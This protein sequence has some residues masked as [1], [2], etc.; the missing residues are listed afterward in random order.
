MLLIAAVTLAVYSQTRD[1]GFISYDDPIYTTGNQM[2]Q[3]G[4]TLDGIVWA[5]TEATAH[6]NYWAPLTWIS[7]LID[8]ELYGMDPGGFHLTNMLLHIVNAVLLFTTFRYLTGRLWES[9][10]LA[11]FFAVHPLHVE[12]VAWISERKDMV[13]TLFWILTIRAYAHYVRQPNFWR[14]G[15]MFFLFLCCLMGKPMG[16]TLPFVLLLMDYWPLDRYARY[17][18]G[19]AG[20]PWRHLIRLAWEKG[21]LFLVIAVVV[22]LTYY[23]Q[24]AEGALPSYADISILQR[25]ETSLVGYAVYILKTF[26]P[27]NL[28]ILYPY[29]ESLP[30]WQ[31]LAA[32]ALLIAIT[33]FSLK[34]AGRFPYLPVGWFWYLG[35]LVP[36]AGLVVIGPHAIADRYTYIPLI[37]V[38]FMV[39]WGV[40]DL[41]AAAGTQWKKAAWGMACLSVL[42]AAALAHR[43]VGFWK[44]DLTIYTHTLR[45]TEKNW[46]IHLNLGAAY[47]KI[48]ADMQ[49]LGHYRE[50]V[51]LKPGQPELHI[52]VGDV[53][54]AMGRTA[55]A[56]ANY[57]DALKVLPESADIHT[58]LAVALDQHGEADQARYHFIEALAIDAESADAHHG[59]GV[60]L[61]NQGQVERAMAHYRSALR[62][63]PEHA[64]AHTNLGIAL[65]SKG[66]IA[67]ARG[68]FQAAIIADPEYAD[69]HAIIGVLHLEK[70]DRAAARQHFKKALAIDPSNRRAMKGLPLAEEPLKTTQ[71][72]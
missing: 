24:H 40:G 11:F 23:T 32:A 66:A 43:Q 17:R 63:D 39:L 61:F 27:L 19:A 71:K 42:T 56:I 13:S 4:F 7:F 70:G 15:A 2:V 50:A 59:M 72:N 65:L 41:A 5:F 10:F 51:R 8:H 26:W 12:S 44:N 31:P 46:P 14:Y 48:G 64:P 68:H 67:Q 16:V 53:L 1:F 54:I 29:P 35:T 28:G 49:A 69:P 58:A 38:F 34:K 55:A 47:R 57:N 52:S 62:V 36:V 20:L 22:P 45:V 25:L 60:F 33:G 37:G 9:F 21:P 18:S 3:G 30:L 6:T